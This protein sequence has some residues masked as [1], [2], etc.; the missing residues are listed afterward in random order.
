MGKL[1][2]I[3]LELEKPDNEDTAHIFIQELTQ[4]LQAIRLT[5][6]D[7]NRSH[8]IHFDDPF[9]AFKALDKKTRL[10]Q[11]VHDQQHHIGNNNV[12]ATLMLVNLPMDHF[13]HIIQS[14]FSNK[15]LS[16]QQVTD[17]L[18]SE[19]AL[20]KNSNSSESA[21]YGFQKRHY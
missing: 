13:H 2:Y 15:N 21:M 19:A 9:W 8:I 12:L 14:L 3:T 18:D 17:C 1:K 20:L 16:I 10:Q 6:N 5:V 4:V 11:S 7:K